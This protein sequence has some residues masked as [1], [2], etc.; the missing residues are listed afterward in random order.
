MISPLSAVVTGDDQSFIS[1]SEVG[2]SGL[3]FRDFEQQL[4]C[5]SLERVGS[6]ANR[7][8]NFDYEN[9]SS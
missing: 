4:D 1:W 5:A 9:I 2:L 7:E 8:K 3:V 6:L